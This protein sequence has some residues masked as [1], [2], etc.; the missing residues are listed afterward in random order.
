[1]S[2][3]LGTGAPLFS[4]LAAVFEVLM[5]ILLVVGAFAVRR[6]RIR[7]HRALQSTIILANLPVVLLWMAPA[8]VARFLPA[9]LWEFSEPVYLLP[10]IMLVLGGIAE[11][12]GIY[13]LLVA[14]T[15]WIPERYRFRR[16]KVWMRSELV[17]WWSVVALGLSTYLVTYV[18]GS[19]S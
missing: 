18:V 19:T 9:S 13:I 5:A 3:L 10:T 12:L 8:Y 11:G 14:G 16:Y 7:L 6:G 17:L 2:G 4:D 1:M 15:N